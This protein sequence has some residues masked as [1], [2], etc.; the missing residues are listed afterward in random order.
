MN[1]PADERKLISLAMEQRLALRFPTSMSP[2]EYA[3]RESHTIMCFGL[4]EFRFRDAKLDQWIQR[5]GEILT[6]PG[7]RD[8]YRRQFLTPEEYERILTEEAQVH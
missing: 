8:D 7:L 3:A 4:H 6:T 2:E 5:L 1:K